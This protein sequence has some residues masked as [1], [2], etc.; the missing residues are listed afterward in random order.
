MVRKGIIYRQFR[1]VFWSPSSQTALAEAELQ[2]EM[3]TS[4]SAYVT[5]SVVKDTLPDAMK[6]LVSD[7]ELKLLIWTTTP[8]TLPTNMVRVGSNGHLNPYLTVT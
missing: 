6:A 4:T 8:W 5:F 2:Y 7:K 3:H 1:P